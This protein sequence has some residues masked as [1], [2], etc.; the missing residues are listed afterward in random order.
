MSFGS[1]LKIGAENRRVLSSPDARARPTAE[2]GSDAIDSSKRGRGQ[3]AGARNL[4]PV[5]PRRSAAK[6]ELCFGNR[7]LVWAPCRL[8]RRAVAGVHEVSEGQSLWFAVF[9]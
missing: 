2:S 7:L 1:G 9:A 6:G 8:G 4:T 5:Y 3:E